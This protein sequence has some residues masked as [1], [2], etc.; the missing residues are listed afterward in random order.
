MI[1]DMAVEIMAAKSMMYHCAWDIA[2]NWDRK[3]AHALISACK[4]YCSEMVGCVCDK[5]LQI[6]GRRRLGVQ[7]LLE[8]FEIDRK[9]FTCAGGTAVIDLLLHFIAQPPSSA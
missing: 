3:L 7:I 4:L 9:R 2:N 1:A 6:M 8:L 5:V